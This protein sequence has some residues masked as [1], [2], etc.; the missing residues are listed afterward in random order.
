MAVN[1]I[2]PA[3]AAELKIHSIPDVVIQAVN[4]LL[5]EKY[6]P[7]TIHILQKEITA[8]VEQLDPSVSINDM[9]KR[10]DFDFEPLFRKAGWKVN[11]DKPAYNESYE[12]VFKFS[13]PRTQ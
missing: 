6:S 9:Y 8:R 2:T 12:A 13:K 4:E 10:N 11:Y 1:P 5:A 7:G 3:K